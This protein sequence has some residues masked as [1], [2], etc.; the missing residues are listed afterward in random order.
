MSSIIDVDTLLAV[1]VGS[2]NTRASLFDVVDGHYRLVASGRSP[3]TAGAPLFDISEG[4]RLSLDRIKEITGRQL[5]D[6]SETL[7]MPATK[8]GAGVDVFIA[9]ATGGPRVRTVLV[10]LM[11]GVSMR[12]VRNLATSSYL[13]IVGEISLMDRRRDE[14]QIDVILSNRPDLVLIAGGTDGGANESVLRLVDVVGMATRLIPDTERPRIVYAGNQELGAEVME[15]F[16]D[17]LSVTLTQNV[18]PSLEREELSSAHQDL[19][20]TIAEIRAS[21]ISGFDELRQWA[22]DN[23]MLTADAFSRVVRYLS[24]IYSPEKGVLGVDL[25]AS[26]TTVAAAFDGDLRVSVQSDL[27]MGSSLPMILK[28]S[29]LDAIMQWLP[30]EMSADRVRDY[31]YNKALYPQTIPMEMDE[32]HLEYALAREVIR[33]AVSAARRV[34]PVEKGARGAWLIPPLEPIIA[35]GGT[36]ARAPRP[37]H[38]ALML[39]DAVQPVGITTLVL[40]PHNLTSALG[41]A[42]RPLPIVA[43]QVLE[44]GSYVSLGTVVAPS[45]RARLGRRILRIQMDPEDGEHSMA[46]EIRMGQLIVLP[47]PQGHHARLTLRPERGID[48]GFGGPGRAGTLRVSGGAVGLIVDARG[49]PLLTPKD[50]AQRRELNQKWL[51]DIG[52]ME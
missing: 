3:S 51:W 34:W 30:V 16:G 37:G 25:G 15:R 5:V 20:Q 21:R 43:V 40:D 45:G 28:Q 52:A 48:V 8:E 4:V 35:S 32:L 12:S 39:L 31:I 41:A 2:V 9:T 27:G 7:I 33:A 49:R 23:L 22:S 19:A 42:A 38:A 17:R 44:S 29:N 26:Q 36:L 11:P 13:E 6:E 18:R 10:G 46:G 24:Q 14:E 1:D 50:P 47:L